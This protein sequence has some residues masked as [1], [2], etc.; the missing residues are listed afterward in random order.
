MAIDETSRARGHDGITLAGDVAARRLL[1]VTE[2]CA[3]QT[4]QTIQTIAQG[5]AAHG[6]PP[7]KIESVSIDMS[8]AYVLACTDELSNAHHIRRVPRRLACQRGADK[9]RRIEQ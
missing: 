1:S 8:P 7:E 9:M 6:C 3:A 4:I 2:G 5:L